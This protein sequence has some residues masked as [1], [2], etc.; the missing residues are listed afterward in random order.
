[1][2]LPCCP[3]CRQTFVP[4]HYHPDQAVCGA[5]DCQRL[6][7]AA[8]HRAKLH[9]DPLYRAQC[10]DSQKQWREQNP[11]YMRAYR[12]SQPARLPA[13]QPDREQRNDLVS[14]L[15]RVKNNVAID[16]SAC[17]ATIIFVGHKQR[18][19]NILASVQLILIE[20]LPNTAS[21]TPVL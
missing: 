15:E 4:S 2:P 1:M 14:L 3:Y 9:N 17:A 10:R 13:A 5:P 18:V 8:Y 12:Q 6:R 16:L 20:E 7:R 21:S 11:N 19:K